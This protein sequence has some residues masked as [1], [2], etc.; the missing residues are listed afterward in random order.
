MALTYAA[1]RPRIKSGDIMA[2]S[3]FA[4]SDWYDIQV[5]MVRTFTQSD[6]CHVGL[7]WGVADRLFVIEAVNPLV[8]LVPL[9]KYAAEGFFWI[10]TEAPISDDELEY[11]LA[12]VGVGQY[13]KWQAVLAFL[14]RLRIGADQLKS[15]AEFLIEC[16]NRSGV[17]LGDTAT[18]A[19][20][21]RHL[22]EAGR[23]VWLV[24]G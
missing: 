20:V 5:Q 8:R 2:L 18:P 7:I 10:P 15:C 17:D 19:A 21:V 22:Q 12:D 9:S 11:A 6:Y 1:A 16:R 4:W 23:P 13:S 24:K 14:R 3:H